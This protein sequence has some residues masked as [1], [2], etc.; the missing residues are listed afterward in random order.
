MV[1]LCTL[2]PKDYQTAEE[3]LQDKVRA[4]VTGCLCPEISTL[5]A[6]SMSIKGAF[7]AYDSYD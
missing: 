1:Q 7:V 6:F 2:Q 5:A 4:F 3:N